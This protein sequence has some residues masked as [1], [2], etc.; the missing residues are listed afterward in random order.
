MI[1]HTFPTQVNPVTGNTEMLVRFLASPTGLQRWVDYIPVKTIVG[2]YTSE[3]TANA[4]GYQAIKK[5][6]YTTS[7]R[8]FADYV[9]VF[10]DVSATTPFTTDATGYIPV[11]TSGGSNAFLDL[12]FENPTLDSRITFTRASA[13][14]YF[15]SAGTLVSATTNEARIDYDPATLVCKGLLIEES[16][17]NLLTYSEQFAS[18]AGWNNIIGG[19]GATPVRVQDAAV[20]PDGTMTADEI[21]LN[22]VGTLSTDASGIQKLISVT[23]VPYA[24]TV[25][26][27]AKNASDVGKT[28]EFRHAAA[29][30][31][32]VVTLTAEWVRIVRIETGFGTGE[33]SFIIRRRGSTTPGNIPVSFYIWGAQFEAGAFPTSYIKTEASQV[34]RAADV[35]SMTGTNFSD[36]YNE[37][38]GTFVVKVT[39]ISATG[40]RPIVQIDDTTG[41]EQITLRGN[42]A[43]PEFYVVDG[44]VDQVQI[45]AGT[46]TSNTS[47]TLAGAY[48]LND[49]AASKDG[50]VTVTDTSGTLPTVTQMRIGNDGTNWLSGWIRSI[51]YY[52]RRLSDLVLRSLSL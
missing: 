50:A 40:T 12:V 47:Y 32:S 35:A 25:W 51:T 27:K 20:A 21:T 6:I 43:N 46:I 38:E 29:S 45:D 52:P 42:V 1:P 9:P 34:T 16:R 11:C 22:C 30:S 18:A 17:T 37:S 19:N 28:L 31:A 23:T 15:N 39:Q 36:W 3:M 7:M 2:A 33:T 41:N 44:G 14:T 24:G 48:K 8:P 5:V 49:F 10:E 4:G 13:G 26:V